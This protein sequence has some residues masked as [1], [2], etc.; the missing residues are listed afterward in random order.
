MCK[1]GD[2]VAYAT[3]PR[4]SEK[5]VQ[6][7]KKEVGRRVDPSPRRKWFAKPLQLRGLVGFSKD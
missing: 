6:N 3:D 4:R 5:E 1:K 2:D 7:L